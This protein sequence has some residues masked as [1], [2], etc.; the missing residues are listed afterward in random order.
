VSASSW[1]KPLRFIRPSTPDSAFQARIDQFEIKDGATV[2]PQLTS[3]KAHN[4]TRYDLVLRQVFMAG[5]D[6]E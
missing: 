5:S 6:D 1:G 2:G 4:A 3:N